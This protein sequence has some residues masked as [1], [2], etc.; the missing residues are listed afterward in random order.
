MSHQMAL[1]KSSTLLRAMEVAHEAFYS[2]AE[3]QIRYIVSTH[4]CTFNSF[5]EF[6]DLA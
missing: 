3:V 4:W 1:R 2:R 6:K 5:R